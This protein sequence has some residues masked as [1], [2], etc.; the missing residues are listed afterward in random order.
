MIEGDDG[1]RFIL[2]RGQGTFEL[3]KKYFCRITEISDQDHDLFFS[4]ALSC[5]FI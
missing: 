4:L 5:R 3:L 2:G 1:V